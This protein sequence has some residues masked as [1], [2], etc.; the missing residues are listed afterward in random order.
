MTTTIDTTAL[1]NRLTGVNKTLIITTS[2]EQGFIKE[3][4]KNSVKLQLAIAYLFHDKDRVI[5]NLTIDVGAGKITVTKSDNSTEN[6]TIDDNVLDNNFEFPITGLYETQ[7]GGSSRLHLNKISPDGNF[8]D[9]FFSMFDGKAT[10]VPTKKTK[11]S[12]R[13]GKKI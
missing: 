10:S 7:A 11:K 13:G 8:Y 3:N 1:T 4:L 6:Y 2:T 9:G 5:G 12:K